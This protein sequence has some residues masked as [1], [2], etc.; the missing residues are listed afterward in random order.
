MPAFINLDRDWPSEKFLVDENR[1]NIDEN[2]HFLAA[3]SSDTEHF[4]FL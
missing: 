2:Q 3:F 1:V 4:S